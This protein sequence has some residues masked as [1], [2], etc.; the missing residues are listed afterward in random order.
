MPPHAASGSHLPGPAV[1]PLLLLLLEG[2]PDGSE[3]AGAGVAVP[4]GAG[5]AGVVSPPGV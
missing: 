1:L 2:F 4:D 3:G 5:G